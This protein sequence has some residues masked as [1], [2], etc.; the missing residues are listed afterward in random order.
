[1]L[2]MP[3]TQPPAGLPGWHLKL[4]QWRQTALA[5]SGAQQQ[6]Q[7]TE[8]RY[9][10]A[11]AGPFNLRC[12]LPS[13]ECANSYVLPLPIAWCCWRILAPLVLA[14]VLIYIRKGSKLWDRLHLS[15]EGQW[16]VMPGITLIG[17]TFKRGSC[18]QQALR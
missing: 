6:M 2:A 16:Q 1:M 5:C 3:L 8:S 17:M 13:L 4:C 9:S 12:Q 15:K 11:G 18:V 7:Q 10:D 14:I